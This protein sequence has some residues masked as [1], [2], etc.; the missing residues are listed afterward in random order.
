MPSPQKK[1]S[2]KYSGV[3]LES[4]TAEEE[5]VEPISI[6]TDV[7]DRIP[8]LDASEENPFY[9]NPASE[10]NQR[11][12]KRGLVHIP[13]EGPQSIEEAFRRDDGMVYVL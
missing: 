2:K 7:Q 12:S 4:F 9:G 6:F 13:G 5:E 3:T 11:Q 1:R 8:A 10:S